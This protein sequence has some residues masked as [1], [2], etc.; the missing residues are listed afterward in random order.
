MGTLTVPPG[1]PL[2]APIR[3]ITAEL[4]CTLAVVLPLPSEA[5][6]VAVIVT[7]PPTAAPVTLKFA[8]VALAGIVTLA[9]TVA[10]AVFDDASVM[11][12]AADC[13]ALKVAV[14]DWL[15]PTAN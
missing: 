10:T 15:P 8:V 3:T 7:G 6:N 13:A 1:E 11:L 14:M 12:T 2:A 5:G 4:T 9:G